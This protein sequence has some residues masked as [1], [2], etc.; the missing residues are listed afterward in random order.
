MQSPLS[1]FRSDTVTSP[2][3]KMREAMRFA[4]VGDACVMDNAESVVSNTI[5]IE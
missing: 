3:T 5:A 1:D 2:C 4:E